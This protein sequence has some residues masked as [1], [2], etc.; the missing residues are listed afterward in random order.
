[1]LRALQEEADQAT[2]QHEGAL[3][4][5][6]RALQGVEEELQGVEEEVS[7][8]EDF[9]EEAR[10]SPSIVLAS[11]CHLHSGILKEGRPAMIGP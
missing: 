4:E 10:P 1:M 6:Q 7:R 9:L 11:R 8:L 3:R 2:R 5:R